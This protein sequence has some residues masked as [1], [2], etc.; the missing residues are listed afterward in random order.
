M[1]FLQKFFTEA[2]PASTQP[3]GGL[4]NAML[5]LVDG[6]D[7][8]M[9]VLLLGL[10]IYALY[11]AIRLNR[12]QMLFENKLL[13]PGDCKIDD[14]VDE[15]GFIDFVIPRIAI[16]GGA[17]LFMGIL[18]GLNML[19]FKLDALWVD[20][21]MMVLPVAVFAWYIVVQR[22]AAKLFW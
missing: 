12:E 13:Y 20:I 7:L 19:I 21:V 18:L 17:M 9:L 15:G 2:P 10:G 3:A 14:C 22:K 6:M 8:L 1:T 4:Q 11:A 16:L 5:G